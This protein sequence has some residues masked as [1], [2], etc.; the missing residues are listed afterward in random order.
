MGYPRRRPAHGLA[1]RLRLFSLKKLTQNSF[2]PT[3]QAQG[4]AQDTEVSY[5]ASQFYQ[6]DPAGNM[7]SFYD[8]AGPA[9]ATFSG[10]PVAPVFVDMPRTAGDD[11]CAGSERRYTAISFDGVGIPQVWP[12]ILSRSWFCR[13]RSALRPMTQLQVHSRLLSGGVDLP[14]VPVVPS[15]ERELLR[16]PGSG[17]ERHDLLARGPLGDR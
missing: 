16:E 4:Q 1:P 3:A 13:T 2:S 17:L 12:Q 5:N 8:A 7:T 10:A 9:A 14:S 11:Q 15:R 6:E